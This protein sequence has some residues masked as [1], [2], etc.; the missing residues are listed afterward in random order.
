M[1]NRFKPVATALWL[2]TLGLALSF[3]LAQQQEQ[4]QDV[5][6]SYSIPGMEVYPECVAVGPDASTFYT[7]SSAN[8]T[9]YRGELGAKAATVLV[10]SDQAAIGQGLGVDVDEQGRLWVVGGSTG[11]IAVYDAESGETIAKLDTPAAEQTF[12]N[13][14]VVSGGFAYITDSA[15]PVIFRVAAGEQVGEVEAWLDLEGTAIEY[16]TGEGMLGG[17]N[18]NGIDATS[19]GSYLLTVQMNTGELFRIDP[20]SGSV[21]QI[22]LGG[23]T[24]MNGDGLAVHDG[25]A[26]VVRIANNEVVTVELSQDFS[27][28]EVVNRFTHEQLSFPA[29][30]AVAGEDLLLANTQF[31]RQASQD[32]LIPFQVLSIPLQVVQTQS[33]DSQ[34]QAET[35]SA[36]AG[37]AQQEG[38]QAEAQ[39][40]DGQ[41]Q[42]AGGAQAQQAGEGDEALP[43]A[44]DSEKTE[45][46]E[47]EE[48]SEQAEGG[49][50]ALPRAEDSEKTEPVEG[51]DQQEDQAEQAEE[52]EQAQQGDETE[53]TEPTEAQQDAAQ[54]EG[55]GEDQE[56]AEQ[57][58][59]QQEGIPQEGAQ[60]DAAPQEAEGQEAQGEEAS[61]Q[62]GQGDQ[63]A[64][65]EGEEQQVAGGQQAQQVDEQQLMQIGQQ[66]YNQNCA[67]CH[68]DE[69]GGDVGPAFAGNQALQN[70]SYVVQTIT[71]GRG[72][73]PAFGAVLSDEQIA[74][75]A[76]F[77]R[78]SFGNDFGP[79]TVAQVQQGGGQGEGGGEGAEGEQQTTNVTRPGT[80]TIENYAPVTAERLVNPEPENWLNYRRTYNGWGFSPLDQIT[81]ENVDQL[82]VAWTYSTGLTEGHE[83]PAMVNNGVLYIT[84]PEAKVI[85][86]DAV[87]GELFWEFQREL[88]DDLLQL[89]PTNRGIGFWQ[90]K[91]FVA[92]TD[93]HLIALEATTGE[94]VWDVVVEDPG[95]GYYIT[96]APL[97]VDGIVM[98]GVSGGE[99]GIRGFIE[100][101]DAETGDSV[102]KTYTVPGEGEPGNE[103]WPADTWTHG[104]GSVWMTGNYDPETGL[105]YWGV[106]N[107]APWMGDARPGDN[108]WTSSTIVLDVETGELVHG[109]Q[110]HHNDSWDWDEVVAP[111][112]L[113][114]ERNGETIH[115]LVKVARDGYIWWLERSPEGL[116]FVD[117]K[118]YVFQ[119]VFESVD[120]ETGRVTY[121]EEHKPAVGE[122]AEFCPS[123]WGGRDWL[124][125]AFNPNTRL[126]Y[127]G[128]NENLCHRMTGRQVSYIPG[129]SFTGASSQMF[130]RE[131]WDH[132]GEMQAWNVD[133][134]ELVWEQH[135]PE[136]HIWAQMLT[137]GGGLVFAGGTIDRKFRAYDAESGEILWEITTNSGVYGMPT[138][139][140]VDGVQY[141]AVQSG[142]GV[143][144]T[145]M[146]NAL[147]N[148]VGAPFDVEVPKG[149]VLWV[150]RLP[151]Q[152]GQV[153]GGG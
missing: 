75:V 28:G 140:S 17:I 30:A 47:G 110:Y 96:L 124:P 70:T 38:A 92:T 100:A 130:L 147:N 125:E 143:D 78:N 119:N 45:P 13:D 121:D 35:Q 139:F 65:Q 43:R 144:G 23:E 27:S 32:P 34:A 122:T 98:V 145:R 6:Y 111:L 148:A 69:G 55:G 114:Y 21:S 86:L 99:L 62:E 40:E 87:T 59:A 56:G 19:D 138:T 82:E 7:A 93:T 50:E 104:G 41:E 42:V 146:Q 1:G 63:A 84:T 91:V 51:D 14:V 108:L 31:N 127:T 66:V 142:W 64:G 52:V 67:R 80:A 76:T 29:C 25:T 153:A 150:F 95:R 33:G 118:P 2:A 132:I 141:V 8:G 16:T 10:P 12:L 94:V 77:I 105:A 135:F 81:T 151:P 48:A 136:S 22:D 107:A 116:E 133:T 74:G 73:M 72:A 11:E 49:D 9:V 36:E 97:V 26:Y 68:G 126:L 131:G 134:G 85:A 83:S 137:T 149:G 117:A 60:Q 128:A 152:E 3:A 115:G 18:L 61:G 120:P 15:R 101:F 71:N 113:D 88:P 24:L 57:E 4:S 106:G 44:E 129:Q 123:L 103:T 39:Q 5:V 46:V 112:L 102:W 79:V 58:G 37:N 109:Y 90:D 53:K 20:E 89:H 54:Q